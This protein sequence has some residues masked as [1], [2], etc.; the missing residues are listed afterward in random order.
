[1]E[2]MEK[3]EFEARLPVIM[4][5]LY[6]DADEDYDLQNDVTTKDVIQSHQEGFRSVEHLKRYTTLGMAAV[7]RK[8]KAEAML[9]FA[10]AAKIAPDP[11]REQFNRIRAR[12]YSSWARSS[13]PRR[14]SASAR[15]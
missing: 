9:W 7:E 13:A 6:G 12:S 5:T 15:N 8:K 1:M 4:V 3:T 10:N 14:R 11:E 2:E